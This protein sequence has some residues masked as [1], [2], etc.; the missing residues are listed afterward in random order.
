MTRINAA[1]RRR[2][3]LN[4]RPT[5][6]LVVAFSAGALSASVASAQS[7]QTAAPPPRSSISVGVGTA[8]TSLYPGSRER[9]VLPFPSVDASHTRGTL[10]LSASV[11]DGLGVRY[12][13]PSTGLLWN[14][15]IAPGARRTRDGYSVLGVHRAPSDQMR[16]LLQGS[17]DA[18]TP[19]SV[20][21]MLG[22]PTSVGLVGAT[23][24]Y[25]PTKITPAESGRRK[26]LRHGV[27]YSL[28][29]L[30]GLPVTDRLS[31]GGTL[32]LKYMS[33]AYA[34]A[35]FSQE[36]ATSSLP[37]FAAQ[38]G[39]K[40]T[41][42]AVQLD[43]RLTRRMELSVLGA[44]TWFLGDARKSPFTQASHSHDLVFRLRF[45]H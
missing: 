6:L 23:V 24:G 40:D 17:S 19:V 39:F 12:F 44:G 14:L 37:A 13:Q 41:Q 20:V 42:V 7:Q 3:P 22:L 2:Y 30:V 18:S 9:I 1:C 33:Q 15:A 32:Q 29:Y 8:S 5:T 25:Y 38:R 21:A 34:S 35:W 45:R 31:V 26:S 27:Q 10:T 43:Y 16:S 4:M 11:L 36:R 28:V